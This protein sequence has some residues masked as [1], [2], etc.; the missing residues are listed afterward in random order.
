[1]L[2]NKYLLLAARLIVG[3][4]FI[5]ASID[6]IYVPEAFAESIHAYRLV[7]DPTVNI[8]ALI[9]P[10]LE[11]LCG[12]FLLGGVKVRPS[13]LLS[14]AL[15]A[16]FAVAIVS[17]LARGLTIDCGCFGMEHAAPVS[18]GKVL[19]DIGL[20]ILCLLLLVKPADNG[21]RMTAGGGG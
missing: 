7:P 1:V 19:E 20:M 4:V 8:L 17:A 13:A 10:W 5:I 2:S 11:L 12:V 18:W 15:F 9:L 14:L 16:V 3:T 6:K 21:R